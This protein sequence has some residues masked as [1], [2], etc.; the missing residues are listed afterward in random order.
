MTDANGTPLAVSLTGSN[1]HDVTQLLPLVDSIPPIGGKPGAPLQKP[2][3]LLADRGYDSEPHREALRQR[4][5]VPVIARRRTENGSGL[6]KLRY[7]VEQSI[8][9]FHQFR[10]L[11]IRYDKRADVHESFMSLAC[12]VICAR[13]LN[14]FF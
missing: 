9:L 4:G 13:R 5:I 10:R 12:S 3:T 6:G 7:V 11:R 1:R 2:K 14:Q 8:A